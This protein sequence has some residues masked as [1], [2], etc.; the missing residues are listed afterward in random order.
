MKKWSILGVLIMLLLP[1]F[2]AKAQAPQQEVLDRGVLA[3]KVTNGV[4]I[5]WRL[6]G[7]DAKETTFNIYRDGAKIHS[8]PANEATN[9]TDADGTTSSVYTVKAVVGENEIEY[10]K[11]TTVWENDYKRLELRRPAELTMPN[12][13][14]CTY[15]PNDMSVGDVDGDGEY[16]LIVKWDPSNSHDNSEAGYT[17][18]VYLDCYKLDGT[19]KW[20]IDLGKNIRAG[21]HYTQFMV[22]DLD[23]DGKAEVACKTAPGTKDGL[24]KNVIMGSDDPEA[25]YRN[26]N[27]NTTGNER[28]GVIQNGPEYLTV[29][30]GNTGAE[31]TTVAYEPARNIVSWGD[32]YGN[33][34]DRFLACI[35]YLDGKKPSL[36]MCRG[37]YTAAF[38]VAY[39]FDGTTLTR[40]WIHNTST[41]AKQGAYG[42]G[43]HSLSVGDVDGDGFD[44]IAYGSCVIDHDGK[45][46]Y[47]TGFGHGDATHLGDLDPDIDGLEMFMPHED[48]NSPY[49]YTMRMAGTGEVLFSEPWTKD[50]GRGLSANISSEH[51]GY[52]SWSSQNGNIYNCKGEVIA[53]S[54]RPSVNFRIY[55]DGDLLDE[56]LDGGNGNTP[57]VTKYN[58][59]GKGLTTLRSFTEGNANSCNTTKSTPCLSGDILGDWREEVIYWDRSTGSHIMIFSTTIPT[60]YRVPTLMHDHHY[61]MAIAWQNVAYNQPPH[62]GYYLED[63]G[64]AM[65]SMSKAS[66][67]G[68]LTQTTEVDKSITTITYKW[69]NADTVEVSDLP[70]GV[71]KTIDNEAKT[72]TIEG[73][74]TT[75]GVYPFT[76]K[77]VGGPNE[78]VL[79]GTITVK[80]PSVLV[81]VAEWLF[82]ETSG[83][84]AA[85]TISGSAT[86]V[87]FTPE[88]A[89]GVK[90]NA[91][92]LPATPTDR[93]MVQAHY[94]AMSMGDDDF[95]IELWFK[96]T[97]TAEAYLYHTGSHG[98]NAATGATGKWVGLQLKNDKLTFGIDDDVKKTNI[99]VAG[100]NDKYFNGEWTHLVAVRN[101]S[102]KMIKL[103]ANGELIGET[104][105]GTGNI[106]HV[107]DIVIGNCNVNFNT[108]FIGSIDELIVYKGV[109]HPDVILERYNENKPT[110]ISKTEKKS[111]AKIFPTSIEDQFTVAFSV[112]KN[113]KM[114]V[115]LYSIAGQVE[116]QTSYNIEGN[117]SLTVSGLSYLPTGFY[118]IVVESA[119]GERVVKKVMKK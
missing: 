114:T 56:L 102:E 33:R 50:N 17:G 65:T 63:L 104:T 118:T 34:S 85:N 115:S 101:R 105:D 60:V 103:Y 92:S 49:A 70:A 5:S 87:N 38:L 112:E 97:S 23:G 82:D 53:T 11:T 46:L 110:G 19:F 28:Q 27:N 76:I 2:Q 8:T 57:T 80:E 41:T 54:G 62:L 22:Y 39:D 89:A 119:S 95:S 116:Y 69:R 48:K 75:A 35:A 32:F 74:P 64:E 4:F 18:N 47:R 96:S 111:F 58:G 31:I 59:P 81:K 67:S 1:A 15:S 3:M 86:A 61:R 7:T 6:L 78:V 24:G 106:A 71:T 40:R 44:E 117:E 100:A 30:N 68:N 72:V 91:I 108:P 36:V 42:E 79:S 43:A 26:I 25:D 73:V 12:N 9:Y 90:G 93:R 14:T 84:T 37:Y 94:D 83:T 10:T 13:T 51:R 55:W 109:M 77:T 98:A 16:E 21:A 88:W 99:D 107:E 20:R 113:E 45:V 52:E 66:G 29:F